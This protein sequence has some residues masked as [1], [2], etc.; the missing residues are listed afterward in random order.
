MIDKREIIRQYIFHLTI[1]D[2]KYIRKNIL[3]SNW[4][5]TDN[6]W[7]NDVSFMSQYYVDIFIYFVGLILTTI[8]LSFI[9]LI[10]EF[11]FNDLSIIYIL[12]GG[13]IFYK[14]Y[15][16]VWYRNDF[17]KLLKLYDKYYYLFE[18]SSH[19]R[20]IYV[21]HMGVTKQTQL[22]LDRMNT[23]RDRIINNLIMDLDI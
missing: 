6:G 20:L 21:G 8:I 1:E 14:L 7:N 16:K 9:F 4:K 22:I 11:D 17:D 18:E 2:W 19:E 3:Y 13:I 10:S 23:Q 12:L 5:K 15:I